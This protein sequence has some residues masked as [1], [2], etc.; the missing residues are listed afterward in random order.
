MGYDLANLKLLAQGGEADIYDI[1]ENK[2]LRVMRNANGKSLERE[3][4]LFPILQ[5][6]HVNIPCVYDYVVVDGKPAEVMQKISGATMI[7]ELKKHPLH[8]SSQIKQLA[9]MQTEVSSI[10]IC[11][12]LNTIQNVMDYFIAKPPLMEKKLI[13]FTLCIFNE[14]PKDNYLCH[15]DFHP[16]NILIQDGKYYIIDWSGA[17][18]GNYLSDVAHSYLLLKHVPQIPGQSSVQHTLLKFVGASAAKAYI[19]EVYRLK[20]F[21]YELF[22]KWTVI[23]AF[24]RVYYGMPSERE[25]RIKYINKCYDMYSKNVNASKWYIEI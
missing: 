16:G 14:L 23:M 10:E 24:L 18:R 3:K 4:I 8:I 7:D 11:D 12:T 19:R 17:Y 2:I 22:S 1:G 13:D 5:N 21:D 25:E 9:H 20:L 15:A 6:H